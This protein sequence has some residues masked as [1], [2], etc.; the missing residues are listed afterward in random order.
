MEIESRAT[1]LSNAMKSNAPTLKQRAMA[2]WESL[3]ASA[4]STA[5]V[6]SW[7]VRRRERA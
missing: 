2:R 4:R 3:S 7:L 1:Y 6:V 5:C